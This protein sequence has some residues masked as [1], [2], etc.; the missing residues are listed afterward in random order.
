MLKRLFLFLVA[1]TALGSVDSDAC[2]RVVYHG[3]G[4]LCIV[5]RSLDWKTPI[6]TN[7]YVYPRG[8]KFVSS[9]RPNA[10]CWTSKYGCV[11]AVGY[12]AGITEGMNERGLQVAGLFCKTA[13]YSDSTNNDRR[14]ISLAVFVAWLLDCN[15]TTADV[16]RQLDRQ[17][18]TLYG[19]T[20]D[21]DTETKLH[22]GVTDRNGESAV[23][24][25][26]KGKMCIYR[27]DSIYAMTND[28]EW[29]AM[30]AIVNYW[31]GV[32]GVNMLP[33]TVRS[34]DRC[35][36]ANFFINNVSKTSDADLGA[37][38]LR[39]VMFNV[40]VPYLYTVGG[41]PNV[42]ST[43]WRSESNLRD[44]RYYFD[45]VTANGLYYIDLR[46]CDLRPGTPVLKLTTSECINVCGSANHLLKKV[47][48]FTPMY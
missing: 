46:K 43:Q 48:Q 31:R 20:F 41:E 18:F 13:Q 45:M 15:A 17:D 21:G 3:D 6:P 44:L 36:R 10:F 34:P 29:P 5:G 23:I 11:Y 35:V 22:F 47:K 39:S 28:P 37:S 42:S 16:L 30:S 32:G 9:L 33:G 19:A 38:I 12:D 1:L 25:F 8:S 14:P 24:E 27:P 4:S 40:S 7:L 26:S 2:T